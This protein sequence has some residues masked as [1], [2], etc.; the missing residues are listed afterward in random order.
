[1][2]ALILP[3]VKIVGAIGGTLFVAKTVVDIATHPKAKALGNEAKKR[4]KSLAAR[5]KA[6]ANEARAPQGQS[7]T[8]QDLDNAKSIF[9]VPDSGLNHE[10]AG[11]FMASLTPADRNTLMQAGAKAKKA[12]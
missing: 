4:V 5:A 8:A 6:K 7:A 11:D 3:V 10:V 2:I 1:M 9:I 12:A